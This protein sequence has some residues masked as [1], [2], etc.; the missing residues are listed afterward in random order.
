MKKHYISTILIMFFALAVM[1]GCNG[2]QKGPAQ[3]A[4]KAAEDA[5]NAAKAEAGAFDPEQIAALE[6]A[7]AETKDKLARG[8]IK[9]ALEEAR[10]LVTKAKEVIAEAKAERDKLTQQWMDLSAELPKMVERIQARLDAIS[11]SRKLP[12]DMTRKKLAQARSGLEAAKEDWTRAQEYQQS[13][14]LA[15]AVAAAV[16]A[17]GHSVKTMK[18]LGLAVS[19][20]KPM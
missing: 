6:S 1:A 2:G 13:G 4:V 19:N 8:E 3:L 18:I 10:G 14:K 12:A 5:G 7:L 9:D 15:E 20:D 11:G 16:A 17:E